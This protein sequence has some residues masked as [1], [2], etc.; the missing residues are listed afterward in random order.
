MASEPTILS[1]GLLKCFLR[2]K[3]DNWNF[4]SLNPYR[5]Y[6]VPDTSI[7]QLFTYLE[8]DLKNG[9]NVS[10]A[11]NQLPYSGVMLDFDIQQKSPDRE[12]TAF[13]ELIKEL[14]L[15]ICSTLY[16]AVPQCNY[17]VLLQKPNVVAKEDH[18][19]DGF[20][21]LFPLIHVSRSHKRIIADVI[22]NSAEISLLFRDIDAFD[23]KE[24]EANFIDV[25]SSH[26]P[27]FL[28]GC[29][30]KVD[31]P[32]Y[33]IANVYALE[34]DTKNKNV[35]S[36]ETCLFDLKI[37][38]VA[39]ETFDLLFYSIN[40]N[41]EQYP[42]QQYELELGYKEPKKK[43]VREIPNLDTE[44]TVALTQS[45]LGNGYRD[46]LY[47][48]QARKANAES[49]DALK[50]Y[51]EENDIMDPEVFENEWQKEDQGNL[52]ANVEPQVVTEL[53]KTNA[54]M[55]FHQRVEDQCTEGRLTHHDFAA[56]INILLKNSN[57]YVFSGSGSNCTYA[58]WFEYID[59]DDGNG[60]LHKWKMWPKQCQPVSFQRFFDV[61][62]DLLF[63]DEINAMK[64]EIDQYVD[65][66]E[67][68]TDKSKL[69]MMKQL[70]RHKGII[71]TRLKDRLEKI[72]TVNYRLNVLKACNFTF[73]DNSFYKKL[74]KDDQLLGV[75][76][77]VLD[78]RTN[79][80]CNG[81][82]DVS[83]TTNTAFIQFN[84]F[85]PMTKRIL[86]AK[87]SMFLDN[88][89]LKHDF[90]E[91]FTANS[92]DGL[93]N[94]NLIL[95]FVGN[96]SNGK[97]WKVEFIL[98]T[99]GLD[100]AR[101]VSSD[102]LTAVEKDSERSMPQM[103]SL[104]GKRYVATSETNVNRK[105]NSAKVKLLTGSDTISSRT[106]YSE[107]ELIRVPSTVSI[108][109]NYPLPVSDTSHGMWR[110]LKMCKMNVQFS[111]SD[112]KKSD[113]IVYRKADKTINMQDF[114]H[115]DA[116]K[117]CHM[118]IML[119]YY[120]SLHDKYDGNLDKVPC[121][122]I[123]KDTLYYRTT[124]NPFDMFI[125]QKAVLTHN[126]TSITLTQARIIYNEWNRTYHQLPEIS[127][128]DFLKLLQDSCLSNYLRELDMQ[129]VLEGVRFLDRNQNADI[130]ETPLLQLNHDDDNGDE[131]ETV[132]DYYK[133]MCHEYLQANSMTQDE[134]IKNVPKESFEAFQ[135]YYP[136]VDAMTWILSDAIVP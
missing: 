96:G 60:M 71:L 80:L 66:L 69:P 59:T 81:R 74:D 129:Y 50:K 2:Q 18:Y 65:K 57:K 37:S 73:W 110:R 134:A 67:L 121:G 6:F 44:T 120:R 123:V 98:A 9:L 52:L 116:V 68:E 118:S 128:A 92:L 87:R 5:S 34:F 76:N 84:P 85:D 127:N 64:R 3:N 55:F 8:T 112:E 1:L 91:H 31:S 56:L 94:N 11:E 46:K 41:S 114:M 77:G 135:K 21:I 28:P 78:L 95:M 132:S 35:P 100:Y 30:S 7:K 103:M 88:E 101:V 136:K 16:S 70:L 14:Y 62:I 105:M 86:C 93:S 10:V 54:K 38:E 111:N 107:Q 53:S 122:S 125:S 20:H 79:T 126:S 109:S 83:K 36:H 33:D 13:S 97:T 51:C 117:A 63:R 115:N 72:G 130:N 102:F 99:L 39:K 58:N 113:N 90:D 26:V 106:H 42:S 15:L 61:D 24:K 40:Y 108:V 75:K 49:K 119:H 29:P 12:F 19:K 48:R 47:I 25:N 43:H 17:A 104:M 124:Q 45:I 89:K 82:V 23:E 131:I 27:V 32:A 22:S 4:S 133:R